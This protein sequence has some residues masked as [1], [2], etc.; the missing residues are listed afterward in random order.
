MKGIPPEIDALMWRLAEEGGPVAQAE[1]EARHARYGPELTRRIRMVAELRQA[2]KTVPVH[3]PT[4]TP[5]PVRVAPTPRWA[6][7]GS[8]ALAVVAVGAIS[9]VAA[10]AGE[11]PKAPVVQQNPP[12]PE[13]SNP[14]PVNETPKLP[15]EPKTPVVVDNTPVE[16]PDEK[17]TPDYLKPR[18]VKIADT[19]LTAAIMLVG[20]GAGLQVTVAPGFEDRKVSLDY[21][22]LNAIDTLHAMGEQ[23]GFSVL[24]EEEGHILVVPA[25][26]DQP[27]A[28]RAGP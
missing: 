13:P 16:T 19:N 15:I 23:Y 8:V 6:V 14:A 12:T 1:F 5:R 11:K 10:S 27:P 24:Q 22:G 18:D 4:F 26:P 7:F 25:R 9:Y 2:G 17:P 20:Q 28:R 3:R 21:R